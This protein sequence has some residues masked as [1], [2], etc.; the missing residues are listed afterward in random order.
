[1]AEMQINMS[2]KLYDDLAKIENF[3]IMLII[4]IWKL[5]ANLSAKQF[6]GY[7]KENVNNKKILNPYFFNIINKKIFVSEKL[8]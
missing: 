7:I 2:A 8:Y 1:M 6:K 4:L 5:R 3:F